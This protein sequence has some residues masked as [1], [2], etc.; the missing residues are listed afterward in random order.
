MKEGGCLWHD[1]L[2]EGNMECRG[3]GS[4]WD[5]V[6]YHNNNNNILRGYR[7]PLTTQMEEVAEFPAGGSVIRLDQKEIERRENK[8]PFGAREGLMTSGGFLP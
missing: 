5:S 7:G 8:G 2:M 6:R 1:T 3:G 4:G